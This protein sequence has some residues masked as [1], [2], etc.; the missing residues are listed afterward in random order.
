M[1]FA[2]VSG[3]LAL[4]GMPKPCVSTIGYGAILPVPNVGIFM[5]PTTSL[6]SFFCESGSAGVL[7]SA[8]DALP[9][10]KSWMPW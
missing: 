7:L 2:A 10:L 5:K 1:N 3:S 4:A 9:V 8:I 6:P